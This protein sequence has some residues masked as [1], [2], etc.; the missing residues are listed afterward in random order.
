MG[1]DRSLV[2]KRNAVLSRPPESTVR[3]RIAKGTHVHRC[4]RVGVF[5]QID[6]CRFGCC[7]S[8]RVSPR[9][10]DHQKIEENFTILAHSTC[11]VSDV[12]ESLSRRCGDAHGRTPIPPRA[13]V[14][15]ICPSSAKEIVFA[16]VTMIWS[17]NRTSMSANALLRCSVRFKSAAL[18]SV[19]P[20][21]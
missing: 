21:G 13:V 12:R 6:G 15:H 1:K 19:D 2:I 18:G 7:S 20:D 10:G 11:R 5:D 3:G 4:T 9:Q 17:S 8:V 16:A 14:H